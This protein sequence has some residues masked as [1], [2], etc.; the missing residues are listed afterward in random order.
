MHTHLPGGWPSLQDPQLQKFS[1][2]NED[3]NPYFNGVKNFVLNCTRGKLHVYQ[4][5]AKHRHKHNAKLE[6]RQGK[7]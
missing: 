5:L 3:N 7:V 6:R 1:I 4:I 2:Y